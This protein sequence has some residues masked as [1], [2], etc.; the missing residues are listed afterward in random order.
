MGVVALGMLVVVLISARNYSPAEWIILAFFL[1]IIAI[2]GA[3]YFFGT[4]VEAVLKNLM[5]KPE[6]KLNIVKEEEKVEEKI[7]ETEPPD[8]PKN[9]GPKQVFH[10]PGQY[11]Y[12][13]AQAL[14]RAYGGSLANMEQMNDAYQKGAEWCSYGWSDDK[15][16]LFPTQTETWEKFQK[17]ELHQQDCGRPGINGGYTMDLEQLLGINCFGPKP[18]Q[19]KTTIQPPNFPKDPLDIDADKFKGK[20]PNVSS[21]NYQ[22]WNQ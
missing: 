2:I 19:K 18:K 8:D 9:R 11:N 20:L 14:C 12:T 16:A 17:S 6:V 10:V 1:V 7:E 13:K 5:T 3:Q 21:F 4:K 22:K 15:M